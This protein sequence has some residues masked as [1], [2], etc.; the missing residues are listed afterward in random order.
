MARDAT[1]RVRRPGEELVRA[2]R[3]MRRQPTRAEDVLWRGI[4]GRHREGFKFRR[5]HPIGRFVLD[6]CCPE[7]KLVIEV[8]GAVHEGQWGRDSLRAEWSKTGG[9]QALRFRDAIPHHLPWVLQRIGY[10]IAR[11]RLESP[12]PD[13]GEGILG[14]A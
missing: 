12:P 3:S 9:Y 11:L 2:A 8:D 5:Q 4:P 10:I 14:G 7:P 13:L 6:C 1:D